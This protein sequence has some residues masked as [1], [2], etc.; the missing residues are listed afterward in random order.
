[1]TLY[2][3]GAMHMETRSVC[4]YLWPQKQGRRIVLVSPPNHW[5][6]FSVVWLQNHYD[7]FLQFGI[8]I[9]GDGFFR[10]SLKSGG[11]FLG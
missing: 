7:G 11:G 1:V 8:K 9:G 6:G 3:V 4:F 5:D 10:F 2:A